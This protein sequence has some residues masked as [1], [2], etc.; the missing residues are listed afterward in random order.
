MGRNCPAL[1][2]ARTARGKPGKSY[3]RRRKR[4]RAA[5]SACRAAAAAMMK[6]GAKISRP[7]KV[8]GFI[9]AVPR[10]GL[11]RRNPAPG[12]LRK[13]SHAKAKGP[14]DGG[15]SDRGSWLP[16][17][18]KHFHVDRSNAIHKPADRKFRVPP[19]ADFDA[20]PAKR[21]NA[22]GRIEIERGPDR[23]IAK[24]HRHDATPQARRNRSRSKRG[25]VQESSAA[26]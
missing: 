11:T 26:K 9:W 1:P 25:F 3:R 6:T 15:P 17:G 12:R 2:L 14:H 24:A 13:G 20:A 7:A 18:V 21:G 4:G 23:Q 16:A 5:R 8:D 19:G 22:I 10:L